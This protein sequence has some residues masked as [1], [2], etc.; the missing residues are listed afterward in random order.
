MVDKLYLN[1]DITRPL[2][3]HLQRKTHKSILGDE[4]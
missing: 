1:K 4:V 2:T 3:P